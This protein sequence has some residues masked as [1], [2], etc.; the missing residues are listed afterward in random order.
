MPKVIFDIDDFSDGRLCMGT[1]A[2]LKHYYPGF[3]CSLFTVVDC[4]SPFVIDGLRNVDWLEL[5]LHG[6]THEPN[7]ELLH[8]DLET[9]TSKLGKIDY[10][11]Y[12][13][14][15]R[16]PG[17]YINSTVVRACNAFKI[18]IALH[19]KDKHLLPEI[20]Y[21]S[22]FV[23]PHSWHG[24]THDVCGNWIDKCLPGLLTRWPKD[25]EFQF[26]SESLT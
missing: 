18:G 17:W 23:G 14:V 12:K 22:Y 11:V 8:Y 3:K 10:S 5:C 26:V 9:L 16:P 6:F 24:H 4:I 2:A 15:L 25:Q 19:E 1:L 21:G 13:R 7:D 20:K